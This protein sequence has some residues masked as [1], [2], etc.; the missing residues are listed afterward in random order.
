MIEE[1]NETPAQVG[2]GKSSLIRHALTDQKWDNS[3]LVPYKGLKSGS[4]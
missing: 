2:F 4:S 1:R 3:V